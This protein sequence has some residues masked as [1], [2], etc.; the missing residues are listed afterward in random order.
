MPVQLK[1]DKSKLRQRMKE[2]DYDVSVHFTKVA[3]VDLEAQ[4]KGHS[5]VVIE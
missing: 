3:S 5:C 4:T 1:V 2:G